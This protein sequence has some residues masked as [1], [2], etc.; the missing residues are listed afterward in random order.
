MVTLK[1]QID[2]KLTKP[3]LKDCKDLLLAKSLLKSDSHILKKFAQF[4]SLKAL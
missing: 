2:S 1:V 3:P 4:A